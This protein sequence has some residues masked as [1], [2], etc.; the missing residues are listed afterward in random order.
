MEKRNGLRNWKKSC[1]LNFDQGL[2]DF[3]NTV[4]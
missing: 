4:K 1:Q 2:S 3:G